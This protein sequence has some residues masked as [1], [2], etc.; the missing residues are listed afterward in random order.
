MK[1]DHL[2]PKP[3]SV[4]AIEIPPELMESVS[5]HQAE[6]AKLVVNLQAAGLPNDLIEASVRTL[7]GSYA[8]ELTSAILTMKDRHRG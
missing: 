4:V 8:N 1:V 3:S 2:H 7:V 5:R 6:L